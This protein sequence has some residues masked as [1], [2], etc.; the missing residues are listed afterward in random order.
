MSGAGKTLAQAIIDTIAEHDPDALADLDYAAAMRTM[1]LP[2][3]SMI[4]MKP[5][6][7]GE[8][9]ARP[10]VYDASGDQIGDR[11]DAQWLHCGF[12][13]ADLIGSV[14]DYGKADTLRAI[15]EMRAALD[16]LESRIKDQPEHLPEGAA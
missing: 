16:Q 5:D 9:A 12:N 11:A 1:A 6:L 2:W 15:N 3:D 4:R 7:T 14:T 8:V 13:F 10:E